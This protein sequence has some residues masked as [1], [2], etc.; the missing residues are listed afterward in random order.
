MKIQSIGSLNSK[1]QN[2]NSRHHYANPSFG[3]VWEEHVSWGAK[4]IKSKGKTDFK[5]FSFPDAKAVLLEVTK[6]AKI[7]VSNW[8]EHAVN[9]KEPEKL[10]VA[11]TAAAIAAISPL[12]KKTKIYPMEN[13]GNGIFEAE[14][15]D[16]KPGDGYRYIVVQQNGTLN[17]VKDPYSK[18]QENIHGW[19]SIYDSDNYEWK[20][21]DWIEGKDPRRIKRDPSKALRGLNNLIINEVNIPTLTLE[22]TFQS[23]KAKIDEIAEQ[24]NATAIEIMPVENTFSKQ[25]GY[26]GVDK[27]AVNEKL[28]GAVG[29]KELI[30]YA[31]GKGLNV[32]MDMVPNHVGPEGNYLSKTGPYK[33]CS[34]RFGDKLNYEGQDNRYVRDWMTNAA[35]WWANEFKVDGIRF[36]LTSDADSDWLLRQ[37][38]VELNYHNPDVFLIAED[39]QNKR[40]P[41]TS[42]YENNEISHED[43]V[44]FID[45]AIENTRKGFPPTIPWSIGFD[46]EW[47]SQYK[48]AV[49]K[50]AMAPNSIQLDDL[51]KFLPTTHYRVHYAYS[52]DE[53]GNWDGTRFIPKYLVAHLNLFNKVNGIDDQEKGQRAAQ[54]AQKLAELIV[55]KEFE[56]INDEK[57]HAAEQQFGLHTFVPKRDL[58]DVFKTAVGKQRLIFG[59]VYTTPGPKMFFQGDDEADLSHF[60]FFREFS[61]EKRH[62][63][64]D[65]MIEQNAIRKY[66]YDYLEEIARPDSIVG[67]VKPQ[68]MFENLQ[69]QMK[70]FTSDLKAVL[71]NNPVIKNGDIVG[72]YKDN[73]HNVHIHHIK[74][75]DDEVLVIKNFGHG[76]HKNS[77]EY[78]GFPNDGSTWAE[79]FSSDEKKYGGMGYTNHNRNDIDNM[80]QHLSLA[81]NSFCILKKISG[82][83]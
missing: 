21:T 71:D 69:K 15:I 14:D 83:G 41:I 45:N 1:Y 76:F 73:N 78:F 32:I 55:S 72:T 51:D 49:V 75:G 38:V 10:A 8:W 81:A 18:K 11:T 77:Y 52:H 3:R 64:S 79:I 28:G 47:D 7:T 5:L 63:E 62:R 59:T 4:Y 56:T 48:D 29:L 67:R 34:A 19:S 17:T 82:H 2:N 12:D 27:F 33:K 35:L 53:I 57:L 16:A 42:Y 80:N 44:N 39:H 23:A 74:D 36:D 20:N 30:D 61:G 13:K 58:I 24:K 70:L 31:H 22:G 66:G 68:G 60:K 54:A 37:I 6:N 46:S 25:W 43:N 40:H 26:D 50:M 65:P 9:V